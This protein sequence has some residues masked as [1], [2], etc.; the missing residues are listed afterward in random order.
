MIAGELHRDALLD[1]ELAVPLEPQLFDFLPDGVPIVSGPVCAP[2]ICDDIS[3]PI[4]PVVG[5][6]PEPI[7]ARVGHDTVLTTAAEVDDRVI[8]H[9]IVDRVLSP[10][11]A[12]N[13]VPPASHRGS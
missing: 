12:Q 9:R 11:V 13:F 1:H 4:K 3:V 5:P 2:L 7:V 8:M 6:S 10:F